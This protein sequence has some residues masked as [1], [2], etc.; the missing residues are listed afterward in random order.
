MIDRLLLIFMVSS[1]ESL[2][3]YIV[4][5]LT[6]K[7]CQRFVQGLCLPLNFLRSSNVVDEK[8]QLGL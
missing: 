3:D 6:S 2:V 5:F 7:V 8:E 4:F 1:Y